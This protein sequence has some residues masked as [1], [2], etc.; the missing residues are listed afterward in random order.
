M[1]QTTALKTGDA[2]ASKGTWLLRSDDIKQS[3][4]SHDLAGILNGKFDD[5]LEA[6]YGLSW[7]WK[8][9]GGAPVLGVGHTL[10]V[11]FSFWNPM[12]FSQQLSENNLLMALAGGK[13]ERI[14]YDMLEPSS[15]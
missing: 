3:Q 6:E 1:G 9:S 5:L 8:P 7:K 2:D 12:S 4:G 15:S 14:L 13:E 11:S 10:V